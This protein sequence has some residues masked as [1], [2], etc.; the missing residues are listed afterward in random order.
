MNYLLDTIVISE[1][2]AKRPDAKVIEWVRSIDEERLYL[3][4]ITIGEIK[5][6]IEKLPASARKAELSS[7]L[8]ND[9][10][11][12]FERRLVV[13]DVDVMLAWGELTARLERDKQMMPAIDSL[14]AALAWAGNFT[15]VT[16]NTGDFD[17][18]G[19][20]LLNPW[21]K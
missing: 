14:I 11:A 12:R 5:K 4:V 7:W 21:E 1:L 6:G 20:D 18:A 17:G 13:L 2:V 16:R 9:L 3:S 10:L 19:I 15:L 8:V